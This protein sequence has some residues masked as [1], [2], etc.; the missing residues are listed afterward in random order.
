MSLYQ[1][2]SGW[3]SMLKHTP[4]AITPEHLSEIRATLG[5]VE[6]ALNVLLSL[7]YGADLT[8]VAREDGDWDVTI[9]T[10]MEDR[11]DLLRWMSS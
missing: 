1:E 5:A 6:D 8:I 7:T 9:K 2:V 10:V 11:V 3:R 4:E